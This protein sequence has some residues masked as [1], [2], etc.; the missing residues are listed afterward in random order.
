MEIILRATAVYLFLWVVTRGTGKRQLSEMT[1]FELVL[2]VTMGDMVQQGVTQEDMSL[3][4]AMLAVGTIALWVI[5]SSYLEWRVPR[6]RPLVEGVPTVI[7]RN[8]RPVNEALRL[9]RVTMEELKEGAC[10]QGIADLG[11]IRVG[12]L[13]PD[14]KFSFI[15]LE[16]QQHESHEKH[17][18]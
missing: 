2:L 3:V 5:L 10:K 12:L 15:Q 16:G 11:D 1:A 18:A 13:E 9:E 6:S 4:G 17:E 8:G 7:V 14:G